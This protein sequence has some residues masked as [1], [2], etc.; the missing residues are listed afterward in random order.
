MSMSILM[1][2]LVSRRRSPSTVESCSI[3]SRSRTSSPSEG[4]PVGLVLG[5]DFCLRADVRGARVTDAVDVGEPDL[6]PL[7][8]REV[9]AGDACHG[10]LLALPLLVL[11]VG[12]DDP[13]HPAAPDDAALV[14]DL[15]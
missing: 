8:A 1:F 5:R 10:G 12:A 6:D 13:H 4:G 9:D 15:L 14:T 11:R 3:R 7:V 2:W